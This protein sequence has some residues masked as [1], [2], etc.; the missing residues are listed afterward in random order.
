MQAIEA[1]SA[2]LPV[3]FPRSVGQIPFYYNHKNT[4]RPFDQNSFY[5]SK[6]IDEENSPLYPF[7]YGLSYTKFDYQN[8]SLDKSEIGLNESLKV[9]LEV[10]NSGEYDG[11]EIVQLYVRDLIGNVTRPVLELKDFQKVMIKASETKSIE[12][13]LKPEQLKFYDQE[14]KYVVEPGR[15]KVYAGPNSNK[16]LEKEFLLL[17]K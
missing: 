16:L 4:G 15:F 10:H 8:L 11:E 2:K 7:G 6:Y 17:S 3:T 13:I 14:M 12:F 9:S 1:S 5:T